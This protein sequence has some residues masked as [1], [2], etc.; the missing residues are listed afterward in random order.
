MTDI[1]CFPVERTRR[2]RE[3]QRDAQLQED[4]YYLF[5]KNIMT[6]VNDCGFTPPSTV[7][8][9]AQTWFD[10]NRQ[11]SPLARNPSPTDTADT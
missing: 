6:I 1:L 7:E 2:A 11:H 9:C 10:K 5:M 4:P 3:L 8:A